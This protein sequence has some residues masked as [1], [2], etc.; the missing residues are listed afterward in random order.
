M[1]ESKFAAGKVVT[2]FSC[3]YVALYDANGGQPKYTQGMKLARGVDL[4]PDIT[5]QD[6]NNFSADNVVAETAPRKFRTGT[7][8]LTVDG[9]LRAAE[10]LI[11]GLSTTPDTITVG[12]ST[13]K[14]YGYGDTQHIPYVGVGCVVRSMSNGIEIYNAH[15]YTKARFAQF[16]VSAA[17]E[18]DE[19]IDWQTQSLSASLSRDDGP[20]HN[21]QRVSEALATE[22]EAENAVRVA[23]GMEPLTTAA[24]GEP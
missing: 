20:A 15:V 1:D 19:G 14:M 17:T 7:L 6:D 13:V 16:A 3:P 12:E 9:L 5:T 11:M 22:L 8:A 24:G 18:G 10:N 23:L 4:S 2:G 21:W